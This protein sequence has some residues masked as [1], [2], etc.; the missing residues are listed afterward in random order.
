MVPGALGLAAGGLISGLTGFVPVFLA[1]AL[2][3]MMAIILFLRKDPV[4]AKKE[5]E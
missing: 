2:A 4:R 3:S 5:A 1:Q